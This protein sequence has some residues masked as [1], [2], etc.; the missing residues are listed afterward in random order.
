MIL[1]QLCVLEIVVFKFVSTSYTVLLSELPT[2]LNMFDVKY[3]LHYSESYAG[4]VH[5]ETTIQGYQFC[6]SLQ[7][8]FESLISED[9]KNFILTVR[10]ITVAIYC[11]GE[12][13]FKIF[14]SHARDLY[15]R[16]YPEGICVL[17]EVSSLNSLAQY[18]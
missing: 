11:K 4:T 10:C 1:L 2:M 15:G 17:P 18:F 6:F 13:G 12:M 7:R 9:Y 5:Q 3:Q 8:A 14:D 16:E